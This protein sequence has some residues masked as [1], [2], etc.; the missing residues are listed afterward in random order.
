MNKTCFYCS[1]GKSKLWDWVIENHYLGDYDRVLKEVLVG[2]TESNEKQQPIKT[3]YYCS[4]ACSE[5]QAD[6]EEK[7]LWQLITK[8]II[9]KC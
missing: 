2:G 9:I 4:L 3:I 6:R 8:P 5:K 1:R 7:E